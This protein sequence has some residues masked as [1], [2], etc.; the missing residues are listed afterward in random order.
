MIL[1]SFM[2]ARIIS[3]FIKILNPSTDE[4]E[5]K[6][7]KMLMFHYLLGIEMIGPLFFLIIEPINGTSCYSDSCE[8]EFFYYVSTRYLFV[9]LLNFIEIIYL[10]VRLNIFHTA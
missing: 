5:R 6:L 1:Q 10:A 8:Q 2:S 4:H 7:V 3:L 9:T